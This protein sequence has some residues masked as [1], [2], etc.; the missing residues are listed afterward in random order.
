MI[1]LVAVCGRAAY[2]RIW[3]KRQSA[4]QW[5]LNLIPAYSETEEEI[6]S[7]LESMVNNK[8]EPHKQVFCIILDG[9][10]RDMTRY[11]TRTI[12]TF[13]C[14][15]VSFKGKPNTLDVVAGFYGKAP[16]LIVQKRKNMGKKDSLILCFDLFNYARASLPKCTQLIKDRLYDSVLPELTHQPDFEGFDM[17]FCT[18]A[19]SALNEGAI[20]KLADAISHAPNAIASCGIVLV[21]NRQYTFWKIFQHYQYA[22]GQI[23]RRRAESFWGRVTCLPGC[24]TMIAVRPECGPAIEHYARPVE[25]IPVLRHQVQY[26][27]TDRRLTYC[28]LKQGTHL[29]TIFVQDAVSETAPPESLKHYLSQRRRWGSNAYFNN[30][31]YLFGPNMALWTRYV[32]LVELLRMTLVYY[33]V[34]NTGMLIYNIVLEVKAGTFSALAL[35]ALLVVSQFPTV[36]FAGSVTISKHLR[37]HLLQF[38]LGFFANKCAAFPLSLAVF[39][40]VAMNLGSHSWGMTGLTPKVARPADSPV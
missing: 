29:K 20:K 22:F 9:Q 13:D 1:S 26:L 31:F 23:V 19:D 15:H 37:P 17:I 12:T 7:C 40:N 33:R 16:V 39:T 14:P 25:C 18:D 24:V 38:F 10:P 21:K 5:I 8:T 36:M 34:A 28:L 6:F 4:P 27:G 11:L 3:P 32:A 2:D 30:Y 35:A